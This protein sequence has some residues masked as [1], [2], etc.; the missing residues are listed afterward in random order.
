[1]SSSGYQRRLLRFGASA[2]AGSLIFLTACGGDDDDGGSSGGGENASEDESTSTT[3]LPE[4]SSWVL[5]A[6]G[7][8]D[9]VP[10][11]AN[12][13]DAEPSQTI[14]TPNAHG[15]TITFLVDSSQGEVDPNADEFIPVWLPV[16]PN[17]SK[18][19]VRSEDVIASTTEYSIQ[20]EVGA[21]HLTVL[22]AGEPVMDTPAGVGRAGRETPEG[23]Y[24]IRELLQPPNPD[25]DYGPYAYGISGF[26]DDPAIIAE[27]GA[28]SSVGIHG[29]NDPTSVGQEVSS[30]CI[31]IPNDFITDLATDETATD[32]E[33]IVLPL[34]TPIEI[35]P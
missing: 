13:G 15:V 35:V 10:V 11:Y 20:I 16:A 18:G 24:F 33:D 2:L 8:L 23:T 6:R 7:N 25:G 27:F 31:R 22:K 1:V 32:P 30:G 5:H 26:S 3:E 17:Q 14:P 21:R 19:W 34:G 28:D 12:E 29:T 9:E 4:G